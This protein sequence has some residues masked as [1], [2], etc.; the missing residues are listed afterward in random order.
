MVNSLQYIY[1]F[2]ILQ[3]SFS[4][5][6]NSDKKHINLRFLPKKIMEKILIKKSLND[7]EHQYNFLKNLE[8]SLDY[9]SN[10]LALIWIVSPT[11]AYLC[12]IFFTDS[13]SFVTLK[14]IFSV[15]IVLFWIVLI[16]IAF[17]IG[18]KSMKRNSIFKELIREKLNEEKEYFLSFDE[19][20]FILQTSEYNLELEW[21][22]F[23][24]YLESDIAIFIFP[25]GPLHNAHSY[26]PNEIGQN[27]FEELRR[28]VKIKIP[29]LAIN[30]I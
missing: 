24:A 18:I 20:K 8:N 1:P 26:S 19:E 3:I 4:P 11:I 16:L 2:K 14:A 27:N 15:L 6:N 13:N 23:K 21:N 12:L 25:E 22:F 9:K 7:L 28:I 17:W 29:P 5:D 30:N 10:K